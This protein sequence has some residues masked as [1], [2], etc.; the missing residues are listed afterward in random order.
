MSEDD[1][2]ELF[3]MARRDGWSDSAMVYISPRA[4]RIYS[5]MLNQYGEL[6]ATDDEGHEWRL[7]ANCFVEADNR[8]RD[9]AI[10]ITR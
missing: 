2:K 5:E 10:W 8:V 6:L 9:D 7:N 1:V 3:A 4:Y